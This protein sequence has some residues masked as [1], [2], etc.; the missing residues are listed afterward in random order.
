M[1]NFFDKPILFAAFNR[2]EPTKKVFAEIKK[3]KPKKLFIT[4]DGPRNDEEK[5]KVDEVKKIVSD[6]DWPCKVKTLFRDK[7]L[8]CKSVVLA[9]SWFFDQVEEGI[10]IE[11]DCLPTPDFFKFCSELLDKYKND[12][13]IM[14]IAGYNFQRGWKR[15]EYSYYFSNY[16][17]MWGWATWRR[18]WKKYDIHMK[19]YSLIKNK[20]YLSDIYPTKIEEKLI[21]YYLDFS[22]SKDPHNTRWDNQWIFSIISNNSLSIVPNYNLVQNIGFEKDSTHIKPDVD[23]YLSMPIQKIKFPLTHPPFVIRDRIADKRYVFWLLKNKIKAILLFKTG[24]YKLFKK[25]K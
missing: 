25:N 16:P 14:H 18:A 17:Y 1:V 11:D 24:L 15:D 2:P 19:N 10:I 5:K 9:I 22:H 7:N 4:I 13:R 12:E 6:I 8:G 3:I 21:E 23:A 20:G